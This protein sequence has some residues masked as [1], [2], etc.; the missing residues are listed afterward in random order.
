MSGPTAHNE[1]HVADDVRPTPM[2]EHSRQNGDPVM[3]GSDVR[4]DCRPPQH[5]CIATPQFKRK[6]E[7]VREN[8]AGRN[9]GKMHR[10]SRCVA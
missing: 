3:P 7:E 2:Q 4:G 8:D 6:N 5:E 1:D 9:D 10:A